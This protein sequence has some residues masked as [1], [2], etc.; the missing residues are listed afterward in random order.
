MEATTALL[1]F[2]ARSAGASAAVVARAGSDIPVAAWGCDPPAARALLRAVHAMSDPAPLAAVLPLRLRDGT[3]GELVLAT[4]A[5]ESDLAALAAL[6]HEI[7]AAVDPD[8]APEHVSHV[9]ELADAVERIGDAIAIVATPSGSGEPTR[10]VAVNAEFRNLFGYGD[11]AI[12]HPVNILWGALT[13]R[14]GMVQM[15]ARIDTRAPARSTAVLY[16]RDGTARWTE[17]V[18]S[19]VEHEAEARH[20]VIVYRDVTSRKMILDALAAEKQ[21]LET[22]LGA[23]GEAVVTTLDDGIVD[24]LNEAAETVLGVTLADAYGAHVRDVLR[25]VD[26]HAVPVDIM[27]APDGDPVVR[28]RGVLCGANGNLDVAYVA[29]RIDGGHGTVIVVRDVTAEQ[30]L[31]MRLSFEAAHDALT[32]LPNRRAFLERLEEAIRGARERDEHHAVAFLD[33]DWFKRVNDRFGHAAGDRLLGEIGRVMARV[34]RGGDVLARI[35]GDE[36]AC[37]LA[38]CRLADARRV[39]KKLRDAVVEYRIAHDG[40]MLQVGVSIGLAAIDAGGPGAEAVLAEADAA[41]YQAKATG[42]NAI[43]G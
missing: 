1:R 34:V 30:R 6:A 40:E 39:A 4:P 21:K 13:D 28:G 2:A 31:A 18:S 11:D 12:G 15:R 14:E 36:F 38:N 32:G 29:S 17:I 22:T 35:G 23:I 7:A 33:L 27:P 3:E 19:P 16:A 37:L 9:A 24:Y 25:L 20:H 5:F 42:R 43:H 8:G 10:I 26:E 41:C